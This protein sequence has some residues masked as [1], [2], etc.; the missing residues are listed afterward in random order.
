MEERC[1]RCLHAVRLGDRGRRPPW[2]PHCGTDFVP[3]P[4]GT[5]GPEA[6]AAADPVPVPVGEFHAPPVRRGPGLLQVAV[7]VAFGLAV[8]GV[9]KDV[10]T[11]DPDK[12]F[13]EQHLNQLRTLRDAPPASVAFR[14]NAGG[15]TVTDPGEVRTFLELVLA[16]EPVRPHDTEPIDEVAVT[17][18]GI[19]DTYLIGRD[20]Q[21]GDEFW[22]RV[23]TPGADDARR[24]AQFTSPALTQWLQRTRVAA[25]P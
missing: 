20:S 11:R 2:C 14:R 25:L 4:P 10:L 7:G 5:P 22:L 3:A 17:F 13:R 6:A 19:A 23:R 18:P 16:A 12:P 15:L 8:L 21:N 1:S 24:V 9:V